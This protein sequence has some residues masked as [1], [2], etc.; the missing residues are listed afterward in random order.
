LL[1][2]CLQDE[3]VLF[4]FTGSSSGQLEVLGWQLLD[5]PVPKSN[6]GQTS[7]RVTCVGFVYN[8]VCVS[9][10]LQLAT[11]YVCCCK[12]ITSKAFEGY[13]VSSC[14]AGCNVLDLAVS[15]LLE[16]KHQKS[17]TSQT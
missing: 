15:M 5:L 11:S 9:N 13:M 12:E 17:Y 6:T 14:T 16:V 1:L 4:V 7:G 2:F 8:C 3:R 10:S